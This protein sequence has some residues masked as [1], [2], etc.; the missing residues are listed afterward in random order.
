[1]TA[2]AGH[3]DHNHPPAKLA[4]IQLDIATYPITVTPAH[5][6]TELIPQRQAEDRAVPQYL[7]E[8]ATALAQ[9]VASMAYPKHITPP[10]CTTMTTPIAMAR[11]DE[12][13]GVAAKQKRA[14]VAAI[15][16]DHRLCM[17]TM[18]NTAIAAAAWA[19]IITVAVMVL[20]LIRNLRHQRDTSRY[21]A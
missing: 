16:L 11:P 20:H 10:T 15:R 7:Q 19:T 14:W 8:V 13:I 6:P 1:M 3:T 4:G 18:T 2:A 17:T 5:A 21:V 12:R 9:I